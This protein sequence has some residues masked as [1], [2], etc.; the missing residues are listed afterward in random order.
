MLDAMISDGLRTSE[1]LYPDNGRFGADTGIPLVSHYILPMLGA[2]PDWLFDEL[3]AEVPRWPRRPAAAQYQHLFGYLAKTLGRPVVVERSASSLHL[4]PLLHAQ[5]PAARFVHLYRDGPDCA[6]SM[7]RHPAFRREILAIGAVRAVKLPAG[8]TLQQVNDAL[9]ERFRGLICPPY[10]ARK[11]RSFPIPVEVFGRDR[12]SPM[13]CAGVAALGRLPAASRTSLRYEDLLADPAASLAR[14]AGF[15]GIG[16]P[17][18]WLDLA[19]R[20]VDPTRTGTAAVELEA[21]ALARLRAACEPGTRALAGAAPSRLLL[22]L[23]VALQLDEQ[24]NAAVQQGQLSASA[25]QQQAEGISNAIAQ[26]R[27]GQQVETDGLLPQIVQQLTPELLTPGNAKVARTDDA[28]S[29][30]DAAAKV[31]AGTQVLVTDGTADTNIPVSTIS[32]LASALKGAG[33]TGPELKVLTGVNHLLHEPGTADNDAVL[34]PSVVAALRA[35]AQPFA[36]AG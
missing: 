34:A 21:G 32:P 33:T 7:S 16:A 25:A 20:T 31:A 2:D 17:G 28:V 14:V 10:D 13:I 27:V 23:V 30:V 12:W 26:F 29:P 4:I 9:P 5:F 3:A 15:I 8:S 11:L 35:W 22:A 24:L 1:M 19:G 18:E 36:A 6:L